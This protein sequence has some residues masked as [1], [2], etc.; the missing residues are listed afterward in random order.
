MLAAALA[1]AALAVPGA[2]DAQV[3]CAGGSA[4]TPARLSHGDDAL[5]GLELRAADVFGA[6]DADARF[7]A[8]GAGALELDFSEQLFATA[9]VLEHGEVGLRVPLVET[10]RRAHGASEV[11]GGLG[12]LG[13]HAR[14]EIYQAGR[15]DWPGVAAQVAMTLPTG[16]PP[17]AT[18]TPL[19]T[20]T[21]GTG[22]FAASL[23]V[24]LE[25]VYGPLFLGLTGGVARRAGRTVHGIDATLA[26]EWSASLAAVYG[27]RTGPALGL[28]LGYQAEGD[29]VIDGAEAAGTARRSGRLALTGLFPITDAW[30]LQS[31]WSLTPPLGGLGRNVPV[32]ESLAVTVVWA[33]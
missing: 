22:S 6:F 11:G 16:T 8:R 19:A 33:Q 2:A 7:A 24:A 18:T 27:F 20:G 25:Q 15:S 28:V 10:W 13:L 5:V 17:E 14:Y 30:R 32:E 21:T 3:C 4:V 26:T 31:A 29:A 12:D 9:R 23:G 1:G